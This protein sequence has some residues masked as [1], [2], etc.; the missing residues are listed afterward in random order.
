[1]RMQ[2]VLCI[3]WLERRDGP[4]LGLR[5][6]VQRHILP[7][8][9]A[10]GVQYLSYADDVTGAV[11]RASR[12]AGGCEPLVLL[13]HS[14]G[15]SALVRAAARA[16]VGIDHLIMLDPV[17]RWLWGQFQWSSYTLPRNVKAATCLYN[18]FSLPKS[19]PIRGGIQNFRNIKVSPFHAS[20][21]GDEDVQRQVLEI[22]EKVNR[23]ADEVVKVPPVVRMGL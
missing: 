6:L 4:F 19:S 20:I 16:P 11:A 7:R 5:D 21:P 8:H 12:A 22:I 23:Q 17:P 3:G 1:M 14:Y 18:P 13:G 2:L 9:P 10:A 15:A